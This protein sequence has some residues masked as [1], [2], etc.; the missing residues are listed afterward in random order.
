[1]QGVYTLEKAGVCAAF[2]DAVEVGTKHAIELGN[3][4]TASRVGRVNNAM[5]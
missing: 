1:M 5:H 3:E 2:M 4:L